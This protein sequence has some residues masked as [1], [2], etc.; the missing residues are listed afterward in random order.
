MPTDIEVLNAIWNLNTEQKLT[1]K[2]TLGYNASD[3]LIQVKK[4][5]DGT[6]YTRD[7]TDPDITDYVVD[8]E[9]IY[10]EYT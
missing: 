1:P 9:V 8:R 4:L 6:T 2:T 3:E 10:G 5:V 7:I